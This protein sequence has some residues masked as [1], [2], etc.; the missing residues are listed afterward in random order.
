MRA[1]FLAL[2]ANG[3]A[4]GYELK[5]ALEQRFGDLL[6][7]LNAGQIYTT[8]ARLER[9]GL[10]E[11]SDVKGDSR[12]KR[13]YALTDDGRRELERWVSVPTPVGRLKDEFAMKLVLGGLGGLVDPD[14]MIER[15]RQEC[16]QSLR[17][18]D[19]LVRA[20]GGGLAGELLI[21][22]ASLHVEADLR[23][24]DR[25]QERLQSKETSDGRSA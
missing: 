18:L 5:Q 19:A 2:L 10:I 14:E 21:E 16:L 12:G 25:I 15:Q 11:G 20:N 4:H 6:P 9:D 22:G 8:L 24:L 13:V 23:W 7:P 17:D 1:S 3:P